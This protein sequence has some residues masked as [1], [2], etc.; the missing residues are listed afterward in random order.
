MNPESAIPEELVPAVLEKAS[1]LYQQ[2]N[3]GTYSLEELMAAGS[4]VSIPPEVMQQAY[5]ELQAEQRQKK[6][7]A[8]QKQKMFKVGSAIAAASILFTALWTSGVYNNLNAAQ[9]NVDGKWAQVENQMQRRADLIPQLTNIAESYADRE[10]E[11]IV[12]LADSRQ[13]FL[14]ANTVAERSA[15]D[16]EM[17]SASANFQT[18]AAGNTQLQSSELF[19]NLQ[20]EIAGTE[21]R[22]ATERM[23]YNQAIEDYNRSVKSFPTVIVASLIGFEPQP[24]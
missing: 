5:A 21:N 20:Y 22:I 1:R 10:L 18:F 16:E 13:A 8:E 23:R 3:G 14:A 11:I 17:K 19:V 24:L 12:S 15:A 7:A 9:G 2:P 4:E 6:L